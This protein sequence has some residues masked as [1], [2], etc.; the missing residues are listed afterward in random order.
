MELINSNGAEL[1]NFVI[2]NDLFITNTAFRHKAR[3]T[4]TWTGWKK[5]KTDDPKE[6]SKPYFHQ[7][8]Y[9]LCKSR[10]KS[11]L[12]DACAH[13]GTYSDHKIVVTRFELTK[14]FLCFP[15]GV[16]KK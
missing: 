4:T 6:K 2:M 13:G 15:K 8:D 5:V 11:T 12:R 16:T 1:L 9:I 10:M 14:R 3:H 7:I